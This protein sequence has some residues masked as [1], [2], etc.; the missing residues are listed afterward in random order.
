MYRHIAR[1]S[2]RG[3]CAPKN[4]RPAGTNISL[5]EQFRTLEI[6][7][8]FIANA[9]LDS[10]EQVISLFETIFEGLMVDDLHGLGVHATPACRPISDKVGWK[11]INC[12]H[13]AVEYVGCGPLVRG[14]GFNWIAAGGA[15][16]AITSRLRYCC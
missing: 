10:D 16:H 6:G 11:E 4:I 3:R 5:W 15:V 7:S 14:N 8:P 2:S 12:R 13:S 1:V 9:L